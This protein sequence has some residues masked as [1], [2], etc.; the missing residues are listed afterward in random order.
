[1]EN[2]G[3]V[4]KDKVHRRIQSQDHDTEE[5]DIERQSESTDVV[6]K[7]PASAGSDASTDLDESSYVESLTN[8][9]SASTNV[10]NLCMARV[11]ILIMVT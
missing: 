9:S 5:L 3:K 2:K 4:T 6:E 11:G 8:S 10:V 1:M 7:R